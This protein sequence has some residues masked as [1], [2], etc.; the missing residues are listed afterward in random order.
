MN[1]VGVCG[2]AVTT[3][4]PGV[5]EADWVTVGV[6]EKSWVG[7][8]GKGVGVPMSGAGAKIKAKNPAQ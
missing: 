3:G 7:V 4:P 6:S 2:R 1:W 8:G 5:A